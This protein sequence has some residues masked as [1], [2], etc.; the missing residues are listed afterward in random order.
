MSSAADAP[1]VSATQ[2]AVADSARTNKLILTSLNAR[3]AKGLKPLFS[4]P[5]GQF[6]IIR[7]LS[8]QMMIFISYDIPVDIGCYDSAIVLAT[9]RVRP[10]HG[11]RIRQSR[12]R[13]HEFPGGT[14]P[15]GGRQRLSADSLRHHLR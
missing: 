6:E 5:S 2:I 14:A 4:P 12:I 9:L 10:A 7:S 3:G 1:T 13:R 8:C 11:R 15:V